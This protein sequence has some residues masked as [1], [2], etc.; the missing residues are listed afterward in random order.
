MDVF[1]R[2]GVDA[3]INLT[4]VSLLTVVQEALAEILGE[5]LTI[6]GGYAK[7]SL[8]LA[9]GRGEGAW[10]KRGVCETLELATDQAMYDEVQGI[11]KDVRQV[12]DNYRDTTPIS[13]F[14]SL[15]MGGL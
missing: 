9:L 6:V 11:I 2:D 3:G 12:L 10:R 5:V 13:T 8:E 4:E 7:L 1:G 14:G 15:I